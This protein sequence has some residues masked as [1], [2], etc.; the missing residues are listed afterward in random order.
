MEGEEVRR[1]G[2]EKNPLPSDVQ[3]KFALCHIKTINSKIYRYYYEG[4]I[5]KRGAGLALTQHFQV[6]RLVDLLEFLGG[7]V[8]IS[9]G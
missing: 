5:I 6:G 8:A 7:K 1:K 3:Y 9:P 4:K 2:L